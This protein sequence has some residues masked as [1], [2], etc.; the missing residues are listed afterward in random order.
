MT[1]PAPTP[2]G[3]AVQ[4]VYGQA[5]ERPL[6]LAVGGFVVVVVVAAVVFVF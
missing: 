3:L 6:H 1:S 5:R 2:N 4:S